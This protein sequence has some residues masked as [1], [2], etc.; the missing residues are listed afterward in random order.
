MTKTLQD[1]IDESIFISTEYQARLAE[2]TGGSDW[3]VD[4]SAPSFALQSDP[5]VRL[6]PY[7]LGT[8]SEQRG[9]WIW[10]WQELGHFPDAV[11]QAAVQA[12]ESGEA[13]GVQE[14][15]T[16][17]L[18]LSEGL[19]RRLTLA[20]KT[21]T[22]FYAHYPVAAGAGVRA[23]VLLDGP[24]FELPEPTVQR[25][26]RVMA[27]ALQTN[28][29][30]H[31][32]R[33]VDSYARLRGAHIAWD[34]EA[35]AVITA[36]DGALRLWFDGQEITG[37]EQA[38]P[39][40]GARELRRAAEEARR[41]RE[42]LL[43]GGRRALRIAAEEGEEQRRARAE[44]EERRVAETQAALAEQQSAGTAEEQLPDYAAEP[45][46]VSRT[47]HDDADAPFDQDPRRD[48]EPGLVS[49]G[50]LPEDFG[51][52]DRRDARA[53]A[54]AEE[55]LPERVTEDGRA[56]AFEEPVT[57]S[58]PVV[59]T[60]SESVEEE[61][62]EQEATGRIRRVEDE[63]VRVEETETFEETS[64]EPEDEDH[65]LSALER[66][67]AAQA[68]EDAERTGAAPSRRDDRPAYGQREE[69]SD[70]EREDEYSEERPE[71]E[72]GKKKGFFSRFF[73]L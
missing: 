54:A 59:E 45:V 43:E 30:V 13:L 24:Q 67:R 36:A 19:A 62:A 9:S 64:R 60:E 48:V 73:G 50:E 21:V 1:L 49:T 18:V 33:A 47:R 25:M 35:C 72:Q 15:A 3:S 44:A 32:Q 20:A 16:D 58:Q 51:R 70:R 41:H 14:L 31:H 10:A 27:E 38:E 39:V 61:F 11:V 57:E 8:E 40:V 22:G 37:I 2:L 28:T 53:E 55:P 34:T 4:F 56:E 68:R 26:G 65:E 12:R 52:E 69:R 5:S 42:E 7:L 23:W 63:D 29:A 6:D 46:G 71:D 17:E 66:L